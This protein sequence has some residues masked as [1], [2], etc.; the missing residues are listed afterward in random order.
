MYFS[1]DAIKKLATEYSA[2]PGKLN[3]LMK[4]FIL[5]ETNNP[6]TREFASQGFARRVKIMI[7]CITNVFSAIPPE[8][9]DVPARDELSNAT[10][11]IQSFVFNLF[12]AIDNLAWIWMMEHGQKRD[13]GTPIRDTHVGLGPGNSSVR[14]TLSQEFQ[15]YLS[16]LD[17]WFRHI[18]TLRHALA[19][20]VPLYI[21]PYVI[22]AKDEATYR[23]F[24]VKMSQAASKEDF[25]EYDR[26]SSEQL[27]LGRFRPWIQHSFEEKAKP[28]VFHAQMLSDFNVVDGIAHKM[29]LELAKPKE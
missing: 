20:R 23:D 13:D 22:E 4:K 27:K 16:D 24:E 28:I 19:H 29:L 6:R 10:I 18:A 8:R 21:P 25:A 7:L 26:L 3:I 2:M 9:S 15:A 11:N 14:G 17:D 12:G 1:E 5:L